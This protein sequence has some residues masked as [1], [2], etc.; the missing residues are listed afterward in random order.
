MITINPKYSAFY[1]KIKKRRVIYMIIPQSR[2]TLFRHHICF[3]IT[4]ALFWCTAKIV[5]AKLSCWMWIVQYASDGIVQPQFVFQIRVVDM[6]KLII[7]FLAS[8]L[9]LLNVSYW[10]RKLNDFKRLILNLKWPTKDKRILLRLFEHLNSFVN[11]K[12][13]S[14]GGTNGFLWR[15]TRSS[16]IVINF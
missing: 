10:M 5:S 7:F 9:Y 2:S 3:V 15:F 1:A 12:V 13:Q 11:V 16:W 4:C 8:M 6:R 14:H